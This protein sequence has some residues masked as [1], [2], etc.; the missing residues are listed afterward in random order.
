MSE[1]FEYDFENVSFDWDDQK[2]EINFQ[3]TEYTLT[4]RQKYFLTHTK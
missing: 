4:Q 3:S 1:L 2:E